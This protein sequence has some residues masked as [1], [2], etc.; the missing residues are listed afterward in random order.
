MQDVRP[1]ARGAPLRQPRRP[2]ARVGWRRAGRGPAHVRRPGREPTPW[3]RL[4]IQR[5]ARDTDSRYVRTDAPDRRRA[6]PTTIGIAHWTATRRVDPGPDVRAVPPR[7]APRTINTPTA[8]PP[9]EPCAPRLTDMPREASR[10]A[11]H[12]ASTKPPAVTDLRVRLTTSAQFIAHKPER[13]TWHSIELL[14]PGTAARH[15]NTV[16]PLPCCCIHSATI[17]QTP[18]MHTNSPIARAH[19]GTHVRPLH[20]P[21]PARDC[22]LHGMAR[23]ARRHH[24][25]AHRRAF[26]VLAPRHLLR[27][28]MPPPHSLAPGTPHELAGSPREGAS[29]RIAFSRFASCGAPP[30]PHG[31]I[32][33]RAV[34]STLPQRTA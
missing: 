29:C 31:L 2:V 22:S 30:F 19:P 15:P 33:A 24:K 28:V 3:T 1:R 26:T 5:S 27:R 7:H 8:A 32:T 25:V 18:R 11:P 23:T 16:S 6:R 4:R 14:R 12:A 17:H 21:N 10:A 9:Q 13:Y 34:C 20:H